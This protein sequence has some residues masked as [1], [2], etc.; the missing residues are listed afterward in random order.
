M[1]YL[2]NKLAE[3]DSYEAKKK[4]MSF[5][6]DISLNTFIISYMGQTKLYDCEKYI[7]SLHMYSS[8]TTG[9]IINIQ[10][11]GEYITIDF[12]QSFETENYI[13]AFI[14]VIQEAGLDFKI[15][16]KIEFRTPSDSVYSQSLSMS[17]I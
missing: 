11:V 13:N 5:F 4:M 6:N 9:L 2:V 16:E 7:D 1:A 12:L 14:K 17:A 15:S 3:R 8:G 10:S